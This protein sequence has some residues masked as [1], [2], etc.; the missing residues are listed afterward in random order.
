MRH[1]H[2]VGAQHWVAQLRLSRLI[3]LNPKI[4]R[5]KFRP[6]L[7]GIVRPLFGIECR[8]RRLLSRQRTNFAR[9]HTKSGG[10]RVTCCACHRGGTRPAL[11]AERRLPIR[12]PLL[13]KDLRRL[14]RARSLCI[15]KRC[16]F[17]VR[18]RC[19]PPW[20]IALEIADCR[21]GQPY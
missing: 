5:A 10:E 20:Q 6:Q 18:I 2:I 19:R 13:P 17:T 7:P 1:Y 4:G 3:S 11:A 12:K 8:L 9:R 14:G 15:R 16:G 21:Y